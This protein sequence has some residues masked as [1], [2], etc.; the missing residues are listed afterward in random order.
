MDGDIAIFNRQPSLHRMSMMCHRVKVLPGRTLRL[1]PAVCAPYNADF[2]GDEMNLHIPQTEESRAEAE[3]LMD[4]KTQIISPRYG[5]S[6]IGC[7]QEA[8]SGNYILT[9]L[10]KDMP[11]TEAV[12]LLICIGV[13]DL[14]RLPRKETVTGN[15]LFSC[16]LPADFD[17]IGE[18]KSGDKIVIKK[19]RITEGY[20]DEITLGGEGSGFLLRN[21]HTRY[22]PD[23]TIKILHKMFMLGC[24]LT[25][26]RGFSPGIADTDLPAHAKAEVDNIITTANQEVN[27]LIASYKDGT[28]EAFPGRSRKETLELK[29]LE[30]LNRTRT[31]AGGVVKQNIKQDTD[32]AVMVKSGA[33]GNNL[34]MAQM[35]ALVGQQALRGQRIHVGFRNRTL[36]HFKQGDLSPEAHGFIRSSYKKGLTPI[37]F[38]Y[39]SITGRD[40]LMDTALRTPKSGYLYRRLANAMQDVHVENDGTVRDATG[41]IIQF[42]YGDDGLD[43]SRTENGTIDVK[44]ITEMQD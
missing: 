18:T 11:R 8:I 12:E 21:I 9:K 4:V 5:L 10:I 22:G 34:Q 31:K 42:K 19:G 2:D 28:L 6:I 20:M 15:E 32:T 16:L 29:I 27:S 13:T 43:V 24:E 14:S 30:V 26:H 35:A 33:R 44:R 25:M 37:E 38:F 41:K 39:G 23:E 1:N 7:M 17:F 40:S 3:H 36:A